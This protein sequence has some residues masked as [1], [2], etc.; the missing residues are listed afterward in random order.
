MGCLHWLWMVWRWNTMYS[1]PMT[2]PLRRNCINLRPSSST[3][4]FNISRRWPLLIVS[5][6]ADISMPEVLIIVSSVRAFSVNRIYL[7]VH[8]Y[9][10]VLRSGRNPLWFFERDSSTCAVIRFRVTIDSA[11]RSEFGCVIGRR[12]RGGPFSLP[13]FWMTIRTSLWISKFSYFSDA[14]F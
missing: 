7:C 5:K 2:V 6:A 4:V 3:I 10:A 9:Y 13:G 1:L 12:F 11:F 14:V 8:I